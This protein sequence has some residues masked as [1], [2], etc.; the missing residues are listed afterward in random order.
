ML[1]N[2]IQDLVTA[3]KAKP[4]SEWKNRTVSHLQNALATCKML[5][6][7]EAQAIGIKRPGAALKHQSDGQC[8]C[9]EGAID[10]TCPQHGMKTS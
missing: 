6:D 8:T 9:L 1:S 3:V 5:E 4:N 2:H 10:A 7:D